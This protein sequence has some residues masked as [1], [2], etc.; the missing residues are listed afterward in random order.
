VEEE[1]DDEDDDAHEQEK[2]P[3]ADDGPQGSQKDAADGTSKLSKWKTKKRMDTLLFSRWPDG[4]RP[5]A[6]GAKAPVERGKND[7][8]MEP[9]APAE[10]EY[11]EEL[12]MI[13]VKQKIETM[14]VTGEEVWLDCLVT[15]IERETD[16]SVVSEV[17]RTADTVDATKSDVKSSDRA[18]ST[19]YE[20]ADQVL[21]ILEFKAR[22]KYYE[23]LEKESQVRQERLQRQNEVLHDYV[24][25][26]EQ[27]F[28][29]VMESIHSYKAK[30]DSMLTKLAGLLD[31]Q[32]YRNLAP[33]EDAANKS[34]HM[35]WLTVPWPASRAPSAALTRLA[36]GR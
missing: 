33:P 20:N 11:E 29:K 35:K 24:W 4:Q 32:E 5:T 10:N 6:R 23:Q 9:F 3:A 34:E 28:T 21:Q 18:M 22:K 30:K 15:A 14:P 25:E 19:F 27:E 7:P 2:E 8:L 36:N 1:D 17:L 16:E 13:Q 26:L 12:D 31:K